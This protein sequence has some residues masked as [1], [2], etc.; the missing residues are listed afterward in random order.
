MTFFIALLLGT[1]L[2]IAS[3]ANPA[4]V[5]FANVLLAPA[6]ATGERV[7]G[8]L[9]VSFATIKLP[10]LVATVFLP[11]LVRLRLHGRRRFLLP[12]LLCLAVPG[13]IVLA[14]ILRSQG[15]E[16][17]ADEIAL[18]G[19]PH[20]LFMLVVPMLGLSAECIVRTLRTILWCLLVPAALVGLMQYA[21]GPYVVER[22]G[23][24]L[25]TPN[26]EG[27]YAACFT[28]ELLRGTPQGLR[29]FS[30]F[31]GPAEFAAMMFHGVLWATVLYSDSR[32]KC[33]VTAMFAVIL[34]GLF[35]AQFM[36]TLLLAIL[37]VGWSYLFG[38]GQHRKLLWRLLVLT[39]AA[40]ATACIAFSI[41]GLR[42]RL[43][44]VFFLRTVAGSTSFGSRLLFYANY[45]GLMSATNLLTGRGL[46]HADF[47]G[48][49]TSDQRLPYIALVLGAPAAVLLAGMYLL[50]LGH[51][52]RAQARFPRTT[53]E[54]RVLTIALMTFAAVILGDLSN[55]HLVGSG[56]SNY[57]VWFLAGC[58]FANWRRWCWPHTQ[59][60]PAAST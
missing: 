44:H 8:Y 1:V 46:G 57:V 9:G 45:P 15:T 34:A 14:A 17:L 5:L 55:G 39:G 28:T 35:I 2:L 41:P 30:I 26:T 43:V 11:V 6:L 53:P 59:L 19:F 20:M 12:A 23:V 56:P 47:A 33:I 38:D 49:F 16:Q 54:G 40:A 18:A 31:D 29:P 36:T 60:S 13:C 10:F 22:M 37:V 27:V 58:A 4:S 52:R 42:E 32:R 48:L 51:L 50:V 21:V 24:A 25:V 3:I 7:I